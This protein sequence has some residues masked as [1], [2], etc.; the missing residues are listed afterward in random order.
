MKNI[1]LTIPED[2]LLFLEDVSKRTKGYKVYLGGGYLRDMYFNQVVNKGVPAGVGT[3]N[4]PKD[5]D[6]FFVPTVF[7]NIED[8]VREIPVLPKTYINFEVLAD[9][10]PDMKHRGLDRV[11]GMFV[12]TLST[13][14]VQF[15]VYEKVLLSSEH[16][17]SDMDMNINQIMYDVDNKEFTVTQAFL[18]GHEDKVIECLQQFDEIRMYERYLR[19][20]KKF[21]EYETKTTLDMASIAAQLRT[22]TVR[23]YKSGTHGGSFID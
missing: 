8:T 11:R 15:I 5:L 4:I 13:R 22:D 12:S 10:V 9:D 16:L 17:A 3:Y 18:D 1:N 14:D 6:I 20:K 19:M 7:F 2:V 23:P 21:P